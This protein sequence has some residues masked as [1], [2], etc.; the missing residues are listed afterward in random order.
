M[1]RCLRTV[2][3]TGSL[4]K[5]RARDM[6]LIVVAVH[7]RWSAHSP[8]STSSEMAS[9][10]ARRLAKEL[11]ELHDNCPA[12]LSPIALQRLRSHSDIWQASLSSKPTTLS[13]GSEHAVTALVLHSPHQTIDPGPG[14]Q[15][16]PGSSRL[17]SPNSHDNPPC[18]IKYSQSSFASHHH[19]LSR[20]QRLPLS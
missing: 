4:R 3:T 2:A 6:A 18:R 19:I 1:A 11:K 8:P 20:V 16:I 13:I 12:G 10:S 14:H 15:S 17:S 5:M 7:C 9:I